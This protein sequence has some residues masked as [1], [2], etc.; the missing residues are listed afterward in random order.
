M[1]T[2]LRLCACLCTWVWVFYFYFMLSLQYVVCSETLQYSL[3]VRKRC[4]RLHSR[5]STKFKMFYLCEG[6]T[7][8]KSRDCKSEQKKLTFSVSYFT[9]F[10]VS[11]ALTAIV[12][13]QQFWRASPLL[14]DVAVWSVSKQTENKIILLCS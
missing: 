13:C 1:V 5:S 8:N 11:A 2:K 3:F 12:P 4:H 9:V 14:S 6:L 7:Q 10:T